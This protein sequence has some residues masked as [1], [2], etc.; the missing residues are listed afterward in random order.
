MN[1]KN[2]FRKKATTDSTDSMDSK[3]R[4]KGK[5]RLTVN[6]LHVDPVILSSRDDFVREQINIPYIDF[7]KWYHCR[8]QSENFNFNS[9]TQTRNVQRKYIV[10]YSLDILYNT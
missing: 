8:P 3:A 10:D 7:I 9:S 6:V 4:K 1:I 5:V 2:I